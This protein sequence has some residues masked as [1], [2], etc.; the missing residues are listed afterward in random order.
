[1][2]A[3]ISH[4]PVNILMVDDQPGK[5]LSYEA[6]L[7][8]LGENLLKANSG[9][10]ALE[11]LL[12]TDI[13]VVLMDVS[14]PDIDGFQLADMIREH[15]RFQK[16]AIIFISAVH[17]SDIDRL[18]GYDRGAVDYIAVPVIPELLRAKVSVFSELYR[19]TQ[20]LEKFNREL[21]QRI[22]ERTEELR[23]SESQFRSLA[24]SIPQLAWM[25]DSEG[26][27]TWFNQRWYDFTGTTFEDVKG[28]G[29]TRQHHPEQIPR[30]LSS[31]KHSWSTGEPWEDTSLLKG[32]D[33]TYRWFLSRALPIRDAHGHIVRWFGTNTDITNQ[34]Q[35]EEALVKSERLAAMGRLAG[36]IAHE[37]NN[38]LEAISN[39]FY[40][41]RNHPS[42]DEE[43]RYYSRLAEQELARVA[44]ITKQTLSFYRESQQPIS[45]SLAEVLENVLELQTRRLQLNGISL[46]KRFETSGIVFG[47]PGELKQ[48]FLNVIG[49]AVQAMPNGGRL[50][51]RLLECSDRNS[52]GKRGV[53]VSVYDTGVG[54]RPEHAKRI[55]EPFFSTK[56]AKGTGLGLWISRGIIQKYEG[57]IRFRSLRLGERSATCF[58]VF[59]PTSAKTEP[60]GEMASALVA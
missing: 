32:K 9:R 42:L 26:N 13:A 49:N 11:Y 16:T 28:W 33:G 30:V 59:L 4:D 47:Y 43:A 25:A 45:V 39:A 18:K 15:P 19:K 27:R 60:T 58:S 24:N 35:A 8:P 31:I 57:T 40:L 6:I 55:F 38:P 34:K 50:R 5:L 48:V 56:E 1:M 29:W 14:M 22:A 53:R 3:T 2:E 17:L 7:G 41:F 46:E 20:Q 21:E 52:G 44:H 37:I 51:V 23:E 54:I 10:E 36:I 12:K